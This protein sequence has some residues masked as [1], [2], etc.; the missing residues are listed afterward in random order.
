MGRWKKLARA[1]NI[2]PGFFLNDKLA[3]IDPLGRILFA[4]LWTIADREG[5]LEDR[6]KKIKAEILPYDDCSIDGLLSELAKHGFI[7]RYEIAGEKFIQILTFLKHQ[8]PHKNE[9]P[10]EI[11][12][13]D[14]YSTSIVQVPCKQGTN[15]EIAQE[16]QYISSMEVSDF[17]EES[18]LGKGAESSN[19]KASGDSNKSTVQVQY[20]NGTSPEINETNRADS[21]NLIPDSF[22]LIPDSLRACEGSIVDNV[23]NFLGPGDSCPVCHG[24]GW[25]IGQVPFNNGL[26]MRDEHITCQCKK[27]QPVW[28]V[29]G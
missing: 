8:N 28:S 7:L 22:K 26:D 19:D 27:R 25:Y 29:G 14:L 15:I 12:P 11:P 16:K 2:K 4:G 10:S 17:E 23:D 3:E 20:K 1:R 24:K 18:Q 9:K 21:L 5:R 6:P 13:S